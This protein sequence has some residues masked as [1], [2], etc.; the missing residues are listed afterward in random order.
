MITSSATRR[1]PRIRRNNI[2]HRRG[3]LLGTVA[4]LSGAGIALT[5]AAGPAGAQTAAAPPQPGVTLGVAGEGNERLDMFYT[6]TDHQVWMVHMSPMGQNVPGP[7][8]GQLIGGPAAVWIPPGGV[9]P[10]GLAVFGRGT[11]NHLWWRHQTSSGWSRWASLGGR[12]TSK[13]NVTVEPSLGGYLFVAVRGTDGAV[14]GRTLHGTKPVWEAWNKAGG[15]LLAGTAPAVAINGGGL[16]VA[17]VG[18]TRAVWV[19]EDLFGGPGFVWHSIGGR[20]TANPGLA[21]PAESG[22]VVA[23]AR[24]SDNAGWYNEFRGHTTG[25]TA[26]WHSLGGQ[27]TSGVTALTQQEDLHYST[28]SVFA[29]GPDN[30]AW[31]DS[32]TWPAL[33]GWTHVRV[34]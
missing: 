4:A 28:T 2:P 17:A 6:G 22:A 5:L 7:L 15:R 32:G 27:L 9:L 16:F 13:P 18:T 25:V 1:W 30:L 24:G 11:D 10:S 31:M 26:G 19:A 20:T 34:G 23:F 12:L 14:W 21:T 3:A 8:G 29:L 33:S